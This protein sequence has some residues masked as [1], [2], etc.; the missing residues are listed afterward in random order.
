MLKKIGA[1]CI[2]CFFLCSI[3]ALSQQHLYKNFVKVS[4]NQFTVNNKPYYFIGTNYWIAPFIATTIKG[5]QR[6]KADLDSLQKMGITNIRLMA[7]SEAPNDAP[8]RISPTNNFKGN[9]DELSMQALDFMLHEMHKRNMYAV[10]CLTNFWPWSG[11]MTQYLLWSGAIK[12]IL[13]PSDIANSWGNYMNQAA[14]FYSHPKA[15][16][17]YF[18]AISNLIKRK[19]TITQKL[20]TNDATI[21]SWQ[22]CNEPR[23]MN[24]QKDYLNWVENTSRFIK[25]LDPNHLVS[26]GSE[27]K[28]PTEFINNNAFEA[29]HSFKNIDYTVAHVWVQNWDWYNPVNH[30]STILNAKEEA[31]KYILD[32]A[33][34]S[35]KLNKPFVLEEF[36][37]ARDGGS[38]KHNSTTFARDDFYTF[39]FEEIYT[40][41]KNKIASGVNFWAFAGIGR[42]NNAGQL[43]KKGDDFIGDPPHE[44]Q[45][46]YSVYNSDTTTIKLIKNYATAFKQLSK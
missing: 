23:A 36:G 9:V 5:K 6:V 18:K 40:H 4:G 2:I 42:P 31:K 37:I 32:H 21:M 30:N 11:G 17:L 24:N 28:T 3:N 19:N 39:I 46:W 34:I 43:W 13:Y 27:G 44:A 12:K 14:T 8:F 41:S 33:S 22:L 25:K 7:F 15:I 10:I 29:T 38:F 1:L 20:Y 16:E 35:K 26:T 45:G